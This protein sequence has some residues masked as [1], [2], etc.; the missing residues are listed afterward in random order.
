MQNSL[1]VFVKNPIE[2]QV[3]TRLAAS[4]GHP[5]ATVVYR[6]LLKHTGS[7]VNSSQ[8]IYDFDCQVYYASA[9]PN[10]P[11]WGYENQVQRG[12]DL[13]QR[14]Y[15]VLAEHHAKGY[16]AAV[17]IGSDCLEIGP[18]HLTAA[19]EALK[20]Y[21]VVIGPANDGGYYLIGTTKPLPYLF[22]G[23]HWSSATVL[24][25]T[26]LKIKANQASLY[27][28]ESLNDLDDYEDYR[29]AK[30]RLRKIEI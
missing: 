15:N 23:I 25:E 16:D 4:T 26:L 22:E 29:K 24:S 12:D 10:T 19:F 7:V 28:L 6:K 9:P 5:A 18:H 13:G 30:K 3:K 11:T 1:I 17:L 21:D 2:G 27:L 8:Q 20:T 14:M